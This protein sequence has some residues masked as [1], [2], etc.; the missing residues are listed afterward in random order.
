MLDGFMQ[1]LMQELEIE[2]SLA[3]EV[4][5]VYAFPVD[6]EKSVMI[7]EIPHGFTLRCDLLEFKSDK[8]EELYTQMLFANLFGMGTDGAVLGLG[9]EGKKLTLSRE[10]DYDIEFQEFRDILEDFLNTVE[11]WEQEVLTYGTKIG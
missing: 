9:P 4:P 8:E 3:T 2:G 1:K 11:L 5:G 7:G 6:E 10:I